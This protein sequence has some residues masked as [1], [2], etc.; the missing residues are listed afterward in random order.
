MWA[1]LKTWSYDT[2]FCRQTIFRSDT[3][4]FIWWHDFNWSGANPSRLSFLRFSISYELE[5]LS[6]V[7]EKML[8]YET[9]KLNSKKQRNMRYRRNKFG[10]IGSRLQLRTGVGKV[11]PAD[12]IRLAKEIFQQNQLRFHVKMLFSVLGFSRRWPWGPKKFLNGPRT[13]TF[14]HP[15]LRMKFAILEWHFCNRIVSST[16]ITL[17]S[18]T[19]RNIWNIIFKPPFC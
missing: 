19:T 12:Q 2:F 1:C 5:S 13:K 16:N 4:L 6:V 9:T 17:K 3:W 15:W 14:A 8:N 18:H 10:K 7:M 11:R